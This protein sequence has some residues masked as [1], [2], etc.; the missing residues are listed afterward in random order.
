M[1]RCGPASKSPSEHSLASSARRGLAAAIGDAIA[2]RRGAP[3]CARVLPARIGAPRTRRALQRET[4]STQVQAEAL[5]ALHACADVPTR[6]VSTLAC[7]L[8]SNRCIPKE[9]ATNKIQQLV[10]GTPGTSLPSRYKRPQGTFELVHTI[11]CR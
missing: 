6:G 8:R 7:V 10:E 11:P 4:E 2:K 5:I 1:R 9:R 3:R